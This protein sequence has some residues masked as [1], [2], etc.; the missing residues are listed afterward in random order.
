MFNYTKL[1]DFDNYVVI[2]VLQIMLLIF[3]ATRF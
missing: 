3:M 2:I 1:I